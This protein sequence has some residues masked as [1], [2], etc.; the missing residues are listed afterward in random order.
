MSYYQY[1]WNEFYYYNPISVYT[2][3]DSENQKTQKIMEN[4]KVPKINETKDLIPRKIIPK[5]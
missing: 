5:L 2:Y 4:N 1:H 3:F